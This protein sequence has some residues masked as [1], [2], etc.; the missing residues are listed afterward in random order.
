MRILITGASGAIGKKILGELIKQ[1]QHDVLVLSRKKNESPIGSRA[2]EL[3]GDLLDR[4][5]LDEACRNIDIVIHLAGL[6]HSRDAKQYFKV[7]LKGT[8]NLL[9]ASEKNNVKKF[10]FISSRS[11]SEKGGAY[12]QSKL[13]AEKAVADSGLSHVI[14]SLS[15]VYGSGKD[16]IEGL[17]NSVKRSSF[18]LIPGKGEFEL[19]PVHIDDAV[20]AIVEAALTDKAFLSKYIIAGPECFSYLDF[21]KKL[22]DIFDKKII[23]I[24]IPLFVLKIA[25]SIFPQAIVKD[26]IPRLVVKKPS[27]ISLARRDLNFCP[28]RIKD[29]LKK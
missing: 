16:A 23:K 10:I 27:D 5:S 22:E 24:F 29:V 4:E 13:S 25:S 7:N 20:R 11:A 3:A 19:C 17:I 9:F 26:Q 8:E 12:A 18:V 2:K 14:L 21:I 1:D 15:E 28:Q 6:T